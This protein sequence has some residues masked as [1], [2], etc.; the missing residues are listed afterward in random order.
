MEDITNQQYMGI[1]EKQQVY[2]ANNGTG[3]IDDNK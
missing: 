1:N 3:I 2:I